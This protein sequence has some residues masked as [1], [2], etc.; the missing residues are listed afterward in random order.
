MSDEA[1]A[2]LTPSS[3]AS[4]DYLPYIDKIIEFLGTK[5][6]EVEF[7]KDL[8]V[9]AYNSYLKTLSQLSVTYDDSRRTYESMWISFKSFFEDY[10]KTTG[11]EIFTYNNLLR[12]ENFT[13]AKDKKALDKINTWF[14]EAYQR[15]DTLMQEFTDTCQE[16]II[17]YD[18][19][20]EYKYLQQDDILEICLADLLAKLILDVQSKEYDGN[21]KLERDLD[22]LDATIG[23][24]SNGKNGLFRKYFPEKLGTFEKNSEFE[25][26]FESQVKSFLV[27]LQEL[28]DEL[29]YTRVS[30]YNS[31]KQ[32]F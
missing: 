24:I 11:Y 25:S 10:E 8:I 27:I 15:Y 31:S 6:S 28:I 21:K 13:N 26:A 30:E 29:D 14:E 3:D 19:V 1:V 5:I 7:S 23:K 32:M 17:L 18:G 20:S 12:I 9:A 22:E 16:G 4:G 2:P